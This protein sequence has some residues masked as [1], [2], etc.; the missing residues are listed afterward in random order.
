MTSTIFGIPRMWL[1]A[2][3]CITCGSCLAIPT[4]DCNPN[5]GQVTYDEPAAQEQ[6]NADWEN[7]TY[8]AFALLGATQID[9]PKINPERIEYLAAITKKTVHLGTGK[10]NY[11]DISLTADKLT[12]LAPL[13]SIYVDDD[14]VLLLFLSDKQTGWKCNAVRHRLFVA[15]VLSIRANIVTLK[16]GG[17]TFTAPIDQ[18]GNSTLYEVKDVP[19]TMSGRIFVLTPSTLYYWLQK[20]SNAYSQSFKQANAVHRTNIVEAY[21][22]VGSRYVRMAQAHL[23]KTVVY[24]NDED[25][26]AA[27]KSQTASEV[28]CTQNRAQELCVLATAMR[29]SEADASTTAFKITDSVFNDSG[30]SFGWQQMD[31]GVSD[32]ARAEA[33]LLFST[34]EWPKQ[35]LQGYMNQIRKF[36]IFALSGLYG[37]FVPFADSKL[38]GRKNQLVVVADYATGISHELAKSTPFANLPK[39]IP[40]DDRR[41]VRLLQADR[42][43]VGGTRITVTPKSSSICDVID[44]TPDRQKGAV[45]HD[46]WVN[47]VNAYN[48]A[49]GTSISTCD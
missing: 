47:I 3:M 22:A 44:A 20:T 18:L 13:S 4:L 26:W 36:N 9:F 8:P 24:V 21:L 1:F 49:Y 11:Q 43:N 45:R 23:Q 6:V 48:S 25:L 7:Q 30:A 37:E 41:L 42:A 40:D 31:I 34:P 19:A 33:F 17:F 16:F 35:R 2:A 29:K 10:Y 38:T 14:T 5:R 12:A 27:I 46:R 39:Q 15:K 32:Q 28:D